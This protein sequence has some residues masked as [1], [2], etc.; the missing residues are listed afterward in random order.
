MNYIKN[1][2]DSFNGLKD[3][4]IEEEIRHT[5]YTVLRFYKDGKAVSISVDDMFLDHLNNG[6]LEDYIK[7]QLKETFNL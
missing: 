3:W 5:G 6:S 2:I 4:L 1:L 7:E